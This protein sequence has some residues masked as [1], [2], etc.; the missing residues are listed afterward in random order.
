M[1]L[2]LTPIEEAWGTPYKNNDDRHTTKPIVNKYKTS[3]VQEQILKTT[4]YAHVDTPI[5]IHDPTLIKRI[6]HMSPESVTGLVTETLLNHF[7]KHNNNI[8][9]FIEENNDGCINIVL[10]LLIVWLFIDRLALL[11]KNS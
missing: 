11:W 6:S 10:I 8:E 5:F 2:P 7:N 3:D 4:P 1:N 9:T